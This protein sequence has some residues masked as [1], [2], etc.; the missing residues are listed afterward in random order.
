M[1]SRASLAEGPESND[2]KLILGR[3]ATADFWQT[4]PPHH[5]RAAAAAF[6]SAKSR[7]D[8]GLFGLVSRGGPGRCNNGIFLDEPQ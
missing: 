2:I 8:L 4:G 6:Y 3:A 7:Q 1:L 5:Q